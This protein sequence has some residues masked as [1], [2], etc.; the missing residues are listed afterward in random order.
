MAHRRERE[1]FG[2]RNQPWSGDAQRWRD[3]RRGGDFAA[4]SRQGYG[5]GS[6]REEADWGR[7]QLGDQD[8]GRYGEGDREGRGR[9]QDWQRDYNRETWGVW[10][11]EFERDR[12]ERPWYGGS[13]SM[14][15][16]GSSI[17]GRWNRGHGGY[18]E[19]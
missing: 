12:Y 14:G 19:G 7:R 16:S 3:Q 10:P 5:G 17:E 8:R 18:E 6:S 4:S 11:E 2:S 1:R 9:E 15:E 13:R